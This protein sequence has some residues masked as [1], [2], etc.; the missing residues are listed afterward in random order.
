MDGA[1]EWCESLTS[2]MS[3]D[4]R[5]CSEPLLL[6]ALLDGTLDDAPD[7][8]PGSAPGSAPDMALTKAV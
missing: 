7:N 5:N 4:S 3:C 1:P 6:E 8:A 2:E